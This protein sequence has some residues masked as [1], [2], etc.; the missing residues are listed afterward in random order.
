MFLN[1]NESQNTEF[2]QIWKDEY[3]KTICALANT[4]G[5]QLYIGVDDDGNIIGVEDVALLVETL[6]NKINNRLGIIADVIAKSSEDKSY[7]EIAVEKTFAPI[8]FGGKFYQRSGNSFYKFGFIENWGKG[9]LNMIDE[10]L[11][12]G[13]PKPT[14][15]YEWN[16]LKTT[17][18][19]NK[20]VFE[21]LNE[22][23]SEGLKKLYD[24]IKNNPNNRSAFFAA[25]L[26][27]SVKNIERWIKELKEK[28]LIEYRGSKKTGGYFVKPGEPING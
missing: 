20:K 17:F 3:L 5:G 19:A 13:L 12:D 16:S 1:L 10:C 22:G 8:S 23:I 15:E 27:T 14:F 11:K 24:L 18:Y 25:E 9:T 28:D 2:K 21:G 26:A 6:P 7:I 4:D